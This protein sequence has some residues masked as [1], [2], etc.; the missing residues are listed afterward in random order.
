MT[1]F[2]FIVQEINTYVE[3]HIFFKQMFYFLSF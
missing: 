1:Y 2:Y 3:F